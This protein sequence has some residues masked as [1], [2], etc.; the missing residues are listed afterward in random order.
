MIGK[1]LAN[2]YEILEKIGGGGMAIVYKAI[3][4]LLNRVITVKVLREQFVSEDDFIRRFQREAQAVAKLSH[5]NIVSIYDVGHEQDFHYL[6]MEYVEGQNLKEIIVQKAPLDPLEAIDY[7][8]QILEALEHAHDSGV[9]H[10]DIKPHNI[11]VTRN[12]KVKVTDFGIAQA[13]SS[14]TLTYTG[15]MVGSVQ[16]I[17]PEQAKGET[18][19][20]YSDIYSAGVVLYELLTGVLP[21][22]GDSAISIALKH[23]Q[24][25]FIPPSQIVEGLPV[26]LERIVMKA[27]AKEPTQRFQSASEMRNGLEKV[28]GTLAGDLP[29]QVLPAINLSETAENRKVKKR[30]PKPVFWVLIPLF[31]LVAAAGFWLGLDRFFETG[32]IEVPPLEGKPLV[33]VEAILADVNLTYQIDREVHNSTYP[34]NYVVKQTPKAGELIKRTRPVLIDISIGPEL[35]PVPG[36]VGET[37]RSAK[38]MLT[39]AGFNVDP[40]IGEIYDEQVPAGVVIQQDPKPETKQPIG[41][42]V[43]LT[44]SLGPELKKIPMPDLLGKTVEEARTILKENML[45]VDKITNEISYEYF[46][47]QIIEQSV[48][49]KQLILQGQK[50]NIKVSKGPGLA[51]QTANVDIWVDPEGEQHKIEIIVS[52]VTGTH[53]EYDEWHKAGDF[54][55]TT[56]QYFGSGT[57]KVLQDG[58]V[59]Y[60][61]S[62]PKN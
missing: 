10:R 3:D 52:D 28:R 57:L 21:F 53:T 5:P 27:M 37:E 40:N 11:L 25:D 58:E 36:V 1:L 32:E 55:R 44:V 6:V 26:S 59:I 8:I 35:K 56:A 62:V 4:K 46:S 17:S 23:I 54:I 60:Q 14:A 43:H 30:K 33:E 7:T 39:N 34:E 15:T 29:T 51:P 45:E 18:T 38:I 9:V 50:I 13:V 48:P 42:D 19:G 47:G 41:S 61:I 2:R 24:S 16:Y 49:P 20:T 22:T 31:F 12:G